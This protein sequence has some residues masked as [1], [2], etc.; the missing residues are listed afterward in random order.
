MK[1]KRPLFMNRSVSSI[2]SKIDDCL[3]VLIV[4]DDYQYPVKTYLLANLASS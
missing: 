1:A 2:S 4:E 3:K